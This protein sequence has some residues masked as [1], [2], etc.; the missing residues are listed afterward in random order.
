MGSGL[1]WFEWVGQPAA[2]SK[3]ARC[4][5]K[6]CV[7]TDRPTDEWRV[8][9]VITWVMDKAVAEKRRFPSI[10]YDRPLNQA[11]GC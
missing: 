8:K 1:H 7:W 3:V 2:P 4:H 11:E 9:P 5:A 6:Q 10:E